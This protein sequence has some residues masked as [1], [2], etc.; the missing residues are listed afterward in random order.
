MLLG[1]YSAPK[2]KVSFTGIRSHLNGAQAR[3]CLEARAISLHHTSAWTEQ[4]WPRGSIS[5]VRHPSFVR[6]T[7][8]SLSGDILWGAPRVIWPCGRGK[9]E[10]VF[11]VLISSIF[12]SPRPKPSPLSQPSRTSLVTWW[13]WESQLQK[14]CKQQSYRFTRSKWRKKGI[15]HLFLQTGHNHLC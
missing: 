8:L 9:R 12:P 13:Q 7:W 15:Q 6:A 10:W 14:M 1:Q 11:F 3:L 2:N 4:S 5:K